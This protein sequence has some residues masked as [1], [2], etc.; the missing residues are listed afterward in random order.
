MVYMFCSIF[1][2]E[3]LWSVKIYTILQIHACNYWF[4]ILTFF[5]PY[6]SLWFML[7]EKWSCIDPYLF[8]VGLVSV[9]FVARFVST[10]E[11]WYVGLTSPPMFVAFVVVPA[12]PSSTSW[13]RCVS[14]LSC[15]KL[16]LDRVLML[17]FD[18]HTSWIKFNILL[19]SNH[20]MSKHFINFA[21][22]SR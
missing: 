6:L 7:E 15:S 8:G 5:L 11:P 21:S 10:L 19:N 3:I 17:A 18:H 16:A 22:I 9:L 4:Y 14:V 2:C 13:E 1:L 20:F 12:V